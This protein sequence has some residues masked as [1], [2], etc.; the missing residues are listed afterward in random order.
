MLFHPVDLLKTVWTGVVLMGFIVGCMTREWGE[1]YLVD[2]SL[3]SHR[4][5]SP[6]FP[7]EIE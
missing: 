2:K 6:I 5:V 4:S 3:G 7:E 1:M